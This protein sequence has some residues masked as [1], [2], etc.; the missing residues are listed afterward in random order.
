MSGNVTDC[1][2]AEMSAMVTPFGLVGIFVVCSLREYDGV[3][4]MIYG[5]I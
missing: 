3:Y 4:E 5:V 1:F 2:L